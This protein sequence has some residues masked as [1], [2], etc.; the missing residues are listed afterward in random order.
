VTVAR[1][2]ILLAFTLTAI[3]LGGCHSVDLTG[4][5]KAQFDKTVAPASANYPRAGHVY[6]MRGFLGI[7]STGMDTL[8]ERIDRELGIPSVSVANEETNDTKVKLAAFRKEGKLVEPLVLVGHSYGADDMIRVAD[9]L[10]QA[11]ITVDLLITLDPVTPPPVPANVKRAIN[12]YKSRPMTDWFPAWRGVTVS[13]IDETKTKLTNTD[14]R[15]TA[16][17]FDTEVIDHINIE[18]IDGV[19]RMVMAEIVSICPPRS[20]WVRRNGGSSAVSINRRASGN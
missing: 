17:G 6:C 16:V 1:S 7:F 8:A 20:D 14:L 12:I 11:G 19:H 5:G 13:A 10:G 3:L 4:R 15:L 9:A 18:K 2:C